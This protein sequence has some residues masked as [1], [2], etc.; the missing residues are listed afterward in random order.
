MKVQLLILNHP[1][2]KLLRQTP[3]QQGIWNNIEFHLEDLNE[4]DLVICLDRIPK[5]IEIKV[6][7]NNIWLINLESPVEEYD[8]LR[9]GY[10]YFS[11]VF[12]TDTRLIDHP[13]IIK[14]NVSVPWFIE[15]TYDELKSTHQEKKSKEISWVTSSYKGRKG[16][17]KRMHFYERIKNNIEI[18]IFGRGFKEIDDKWDAI[19]PYKYSIAVENHS[20]KYYWTEK[21]QDVF[22]SGTMPVYYGCK[23]ITK[24]F[25]K[26][27]ML[28]ID[29]NKPKKA[30]RIIE[31]AIQD[32]LYEKNIDAIKYA[33]NLVL[34]KYQFFPQVS[35]W[36]KQ[37]A[38]QNSE[39]EIVKLKHLTNLYPHEKQ[40][41]SRIH[42]YIFLLKKMLLFNEYQ[43]PDSKRFGQV[44]Y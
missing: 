2:R 36:I 39:K 1:Y 26:E 23:E 21:I 43:N 33:K 20:G 15:K 7:K 40:N 8:W 22:L 3:K 31:K 14:T 37:Y 19:A 25:P 35:E 13:K 38:E 29:I 17:K 44:T 32:N 12:C 42:R 5:D 34:D 27:S 16:H 10:K 11:K 4:A 28:L 9:K 24:Y 41:Y 30:I 6:P 18:D